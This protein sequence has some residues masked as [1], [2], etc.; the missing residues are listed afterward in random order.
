MQ[1]RNGRA[2]INGSG[3]VAAG[4]KTAEVTLPY[5]GTLRVCTSTSVTL[6]V[7]NSAPPGGMAGLLMAMDHGA[8]EMSFA[9][10]PRD[11]NVD[12]L[13]TPDFRILIGGPGASE[14]KVRLGL[15]GDTCV[16]NSGSD[17]P[18]IVVSSLFDSGIY[19]VQPGQ[20]VTFQHGSVRE[21]IDQEKEPC[22]CPP[23][24]PK[25]NGNEFPLAQSEGL[26]PLPPVPAPPKSDQVAAPTQTGNV[27]PPLVYP[28]KPQEEP[29]P[30][31]PTTQPA[32]V[33]T[34]QPASSTKVKKPGVFRRIGHF[35][36][37]AFGA[38]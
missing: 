4:D 14:V 25:P 11:A 30:V 36:R 10:T 15:Q 1:A 5:R 7:D 27:V 23:E 24:I 32:P 9:A 31:A 22:G 35:F 20:R 37:R 34:A 17:G 18:Y 8:V 19:R 28:A 33:P 12:T 13:M 16:D 21:V 29:P 2:Y 38:E 26:A 6:A 3:S